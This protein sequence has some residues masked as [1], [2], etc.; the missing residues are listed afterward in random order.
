VTRLSKPRAMVSTSGSSGMKSVYRLQAS[1]FRRRA[2]GKPVGRRLQP[3]AHSLTPNCHLS[4]AGVIITSTPL[5]R[6][7]PL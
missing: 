7:Y 6:L 4:P 1:A 3:D 2:S 5:L